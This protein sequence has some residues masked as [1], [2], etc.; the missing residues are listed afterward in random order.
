MDSDESRMWMLTFCLDLL[1][2]GESEVRS[3]EIRVVRVGHCRCRL[4]GMERMWLE[5]TEDE[6]CCE[7]KQDK[8]RERVIIA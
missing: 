7:K 1:T 4:F 3:E 6:L 2:L 8:V 5:E